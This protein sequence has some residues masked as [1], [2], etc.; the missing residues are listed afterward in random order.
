[1]YMHLY[2]VARRYRLAYVHDRPLELEAHIN[3][4]SKYP[5]MMKLELRQ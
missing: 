2:K 4:R 3:L 5:L 1:M